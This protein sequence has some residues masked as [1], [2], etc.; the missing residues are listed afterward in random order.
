[1][2][3]ILATSDGQEERTIFDDVDFEIGGENTFEIAVDYPSWQGDY[4]FGKRVYIPG[5]EYGGIIKAIEGS[6]V[7]DQIFV[8]GYVWR[9]YLM[10]RIIE[11]PSG[12][13]YYTVSGELNECI[14]TVLD[15]SLGSLFQVSSEDTGV[16]V[17]SY[18]FNRYV[19]VEE[20]LTAMLESVGYRL[21]IEYVQTEL[22]GYV[23]VSAVE[24]VDYGEEVDISQDGQLDFSSLDYRMGVN[25]LICLGS[26][27]LAQRLVVHLY[28]DAN[29][30][31]STT[32]SI[33]GIDEI[34]EV[35]DNNGIDDSETMTEMG[36]DYMKELLSY[37]QFDATSK[38]LDDIDL[39]LGD[40][41][42]GRDYVTGTVVT[43]PI[44]IKIAH[45]Q[46]GLFSYEYRIKGEE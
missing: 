2:E 45:R 40:T 1:M 31:I 34:V 15:S 25:H 24:A 12:S 10:K 41:I 4:T 30:N 3:M 13:D 35:Y 19:T 32:Q 28:A 27:E 9:G 16:S 42:T 14:S 8:R 21:N 20:G 38:D 26:G 22:S 46:G 11:P 5:T 29:G 7:T 39:P 17:S 18:Q 36:I 23:E 44:V 33:T 37:K 43:Q 6:T